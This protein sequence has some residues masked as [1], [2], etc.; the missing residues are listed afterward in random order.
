MAAPVVVVGV[1]GSAGSAGA[2]SW[3]LDHAR[4]RGGSVR[5]VMAWDYPSLAMMPTPVG[6]PVP[7]PDAMEAAA[8]ATLAQLLG[9][10]RSSA[11]VEVAEVVTRGPAAQVLVTQ[12]T[13]VGA[14]LVVVGNRGAGRVRSVLLGSVSRKVATSA[15]CPVAVIPE[16]ATPGVAGPVVVGVDGSASS[17]TALR[18]AGEATDGPIRAIHVFE[19][20]YGPE[21]AVEDF[22][23]EHPQDLGRQ[24]LE[25]AVADTLGDRTDVTAEATEGDAREVLTAASAGASMVVVG[26]RGTTGL[27]WLILGSVTTDLASRADA[28][29]VIVPGS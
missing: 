27:D 9:P 25:R 5:V 19:Y 8:E 12:A 18:W 3:A 11:G 21:F 23:W 14:D 24:M 15:P 13:D 2:L 10:L 1:D 6:N 16:G 22:E 4:R 20:P 26:S 17:L 7:P 29:V 28:P